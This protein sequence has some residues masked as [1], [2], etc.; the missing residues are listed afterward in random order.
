MNH[1][2]NAALG[3]IDNMRSDYNISELQKIPKAEYIEL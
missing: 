3:A 1:T 2:D